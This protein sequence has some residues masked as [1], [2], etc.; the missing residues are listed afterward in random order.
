VDISPTFSDYIE[1]ALI[2]LSQPLWNVALDGFCN[3]DPGSI[4]DAPAK[5]IKAGDHG[6][7]GGENMIRF[8]D[9][10]VRYLTVI[11]AKRIQ[12]FPD[13]FIIKG[14]WIIILLQLFPP[15]I[16]NIR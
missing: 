3:H 6:V 13:N 10:T 9:E 8:A 12:T 15:P 14:A 16:N 7:P 11:E 2:K 4:L 1:A 5:T